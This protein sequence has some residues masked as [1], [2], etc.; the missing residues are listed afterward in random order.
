M[1]NLLHAFDA[2]GNN[3]II[4]VGADDRENEWIGE[5]MAL[6]IPSTSNY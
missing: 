1:T 2:A 6:N 5:G 4:V 3:L